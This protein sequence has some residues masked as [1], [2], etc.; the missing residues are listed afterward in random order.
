MF[1]LM[2]LSLIFFGAGGHQ[3]HFITSVTIAVR[4]G[5]FSVHFRKLNL[6]CQDQSK[7]FS[8]R[9]S[10][11]CHSV[12]GPGYES[13]TIFNSVSHL[14][15]T[16]C[17]WSSGSASPCWWGSLRWNLSRTQLCWI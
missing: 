5:M 13:D 3:S 17:N 2:I 1:I 12:C 9:S 6:V 16:Y 15:W 8:V 4:I 11:I 10:L 14:G 7:P